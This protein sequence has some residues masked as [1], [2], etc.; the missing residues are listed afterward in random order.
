MKNVIILLISLGALFSTSCSERTAK[1]LD[2]VIATSTEYTE[3]SFAKESADKTISAEAHVES[4]Y[5]LSQVDVAPL[6][7]EPC[8]EKDVRICTQKNLGAFIK[9]NIEMPKE[10]I[11][12]NHSGLEH[13]KVVIE[14]DGSMRDIEYV[15]T[16]KENCDWCQQTA[17]NVVGKMTQW[18]PALKNGKPVPVELVIPIKFLG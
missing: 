11:S 15:D 12:S 7:G 10:S 14:I 1:E 16:K 17:V 8:Q 4:I 2:N 3:Q 5:K 18:R 6:F 13:V 9:N